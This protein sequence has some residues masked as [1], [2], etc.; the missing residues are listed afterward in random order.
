MAIKYSGDKK[1]ATAATRIIIALLIGLAA[2][3]ATGKAIRWS[4]APLVGWDVAVAVYLS[5]I[6]STI[7][8]LDNKLTADFA[9]R[10]DP[11]RGIGDMVLITASIASLAAVGVVL[12]GAGQA[13][14]AHS[15]WYVGFGIISVLLAWALTHT[16]FM[17]RYA[18]LYYRNPKQAVEFDGAN[19]Q[20]TYTDFAYLA[21]TMAMTFQVSDTGF[22]STKFRGLA[23]RHALLS[24]LFGTII[25]ATTINLVAGLIG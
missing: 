14:R 20:P 19:N 13:S 12:I 11:S 1:T 24:Y 8:R 7:F 3:L 6:W 4:L 2:A 16:I 18:E 17:L 25:V 5:W 9:L 21:F 10:E 22:Q 23:L 15:L